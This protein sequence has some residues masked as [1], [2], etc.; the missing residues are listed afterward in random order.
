MKGLIKGLLNIIDFI[1]FFVRIVNQIFNNTIRVIKYLLAI[2]PKITT[3]I[4]GLPP[5]IQIF[6]TMTIGICVAYF[7][8][9]RHH[10]RSDE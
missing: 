8:I 10:G 9:G 5:Y 2:L 7:I 4:L 3:I 1:K 6:A